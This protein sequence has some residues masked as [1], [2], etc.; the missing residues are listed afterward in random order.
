M[1]EM[2]RVGATAGGG[3]NRLTLTDA[4]REARDLFA[5]WA[6]DAGLELRIDEMGNMF[7]RRAGRENDTPPA[8][9]G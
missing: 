3:V 6:G 8:M 4:D 9:A 7:A 5:A 1:E 2:A